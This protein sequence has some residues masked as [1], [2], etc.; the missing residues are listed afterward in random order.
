MSEYEKTLKIF[1]ERIYEPLGEILSKKGDE[2]FVSDGVGLVKKIFEESPTIFD[3]LLTKEAAEGYTRKKVIC[4][5]GR[6]AARCMEWASDA[7]SPVHEHGG[8]VCFDIV[9]EGKI[10]V[11]DYEPKKIE[12]KSSRG[13]AL[14]E[15]I[16][17]S[18][19]SASRG[20]F[21]VVDPFKNSFEAHAVSSPDG[22]S[23]SLHFYPI[24]HRSIYIYQ[25][26]GENLF[27][28]VS[29]SLADD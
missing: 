23:K 19:Y 2:G 14:Y 5:N 10:E 3:S 9:L 22:K 16:E 4:D 11:V 7:K 8:R 25:A 29:H 1:R 21:V 6:H 28:K 15:L 12:D 20:E 24:D 13:E 18:R 27:R 26:Q 17:K